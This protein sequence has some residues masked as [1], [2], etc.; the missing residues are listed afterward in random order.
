MDPH[1]FAFFSGIKKLTEGSESDR[2]AAS[3]TIFGRN[4]FLMEIRVQKYFSIHESS[5][6]EG[7]FE[8]LLPESSAN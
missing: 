1:Y 4:G 2:S 7:M 3:I 8:E 5:P 6:T